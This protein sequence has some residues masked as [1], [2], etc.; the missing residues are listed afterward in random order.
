MATLRLQ[1]L[2]EVAPIQGPDAT[3]RFD[4]RTGEEAI[5]RGIAQLGGEAAQ[6]AIAV[7]GRADLAAVEDAETRYQQSANAALYGQNGD[8]KGLL[9]AQ[10]DDA[11]K[12]SVPTLQGLQKSRDEIA[13]TLANDDQRAAFVRRADAHYTLAQRQVEAHTG[14]QIKVVEGQRFD[15]KKGA[16]LDTIANGY[17]DPDV[18]VG[19][20]QR[21]E[22]L[23]MMEAKR[24]GLEGWQTYPPDPATPAGQLLQAWRSEVA[25]T[26]LER[27]LIDKDA[28]R[29]KAFLAQPVAAPGTPELPPVPEGGTPH[30]LGKPILKNPDGSWSTESTITIESDGKSLVLPTIIGG[31]RYSNQE[32][33]AAW[34]AGKND[35]VGTFDDPAVAETDAQ[36]RHLEEQQLRGGEAK[37]GPRTNLELLGADAPKYLERLRHV[38]D[39]TEAY[40]VAAR[41]VDE[42]TDK[43]SGRV[44]EELAREAL[45]EFASPAL[46]REAHLNLESLLNAAGEDWKRQV[47]DRWNTAKT[48]YLG[49]PD[50]KGRRG[51]GAIDGQT[52]SWLIRYAPD[53]WKHLQ[54]WAN[55]DAEHAKNAPPTAEQESAFTSIAVRMSDHPEE[56]V[57]VDGPG[58]ED[59]Y[60]SQVAPRDRHALLGHFLQTKAVAHK[61]DETLPKTVVQEILSKGR[62]GGGG[63]SLFPAKGDDPALWSP[64]KSQLFSTIY[65]DLL[66]LQADEKLRT[67]KPPDPKV[68]S[69]RIDWWMRRG[70]VK[71]SGTFLDDSGVPRVKAATSPD[72][73]GKDFEPEPLAVPDGPAKEFRQ[74]LRANR[75]AAI[76]DTPAV[77]EYLWSLDPRNPKRDANAKPPPEF[78]E[79][80]DLDRAEAAGRARVGTLSP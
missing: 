3:L 70:T 76:R 2:P 10:G 51:L 41:A 43:E 52:S 62:P 28:P 66:Q 45:K 58:F 16:S 31:R 18:V 15:A 24:R 17:N 23:V 33:V 60:L 71:G 14:Q 8:G 21:F 55:A 36:Q 32:A 67:G 77:L 13:Q 4:P 48:A 59:R 5:G 80:V 46:R 40:D 39:Q 9:Q 49:G 35:P 1:T 27:F 26:V 25:K 61:P 44:N 47:G 64:D 69:A 73:Q 63:A 50:Q 38:Q 65:R 22:P 75:K 19:E 7:K 20:R 54:D 72:Y 30:D 57:G 34:K 78:F 74:L 12:R 79:P 42:A 29:A 37:G 56:F 6:M 53:T 68:L 11:V